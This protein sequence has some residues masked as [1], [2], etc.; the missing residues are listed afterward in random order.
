MKNE[1][2]IGNYVT[3]EG[4]VIELRSRDIYHF[5]KSGLKLKPIPLTKQWLLDFGFR[6]CE[7]GLSIKLNDDIILDWDSTT[8][9]WMSVDDYINSMIDLSEKCNHVHQLQ[10]LYF[11]L[12]GEELKLNQSL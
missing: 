11:A 9:T 10:N 7:G 3:C 1:L 5:D 4:K 2:R 8:G 12:T 6:E